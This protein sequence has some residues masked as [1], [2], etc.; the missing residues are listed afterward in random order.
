MSMYNLDSSREDLDVP[1]H[2]YTI[3]IIHNV[4]LHMHMQEVH[5]S[6]IKEK[7]M[8]ERQSVIKE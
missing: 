4:P 2:R 7:I 6:P 1:S 8:S 5:S 3:V